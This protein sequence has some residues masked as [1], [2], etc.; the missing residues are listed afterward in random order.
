M[1]VLIILSWILDT[2]LHYHLPFLP[3]YFLYFQPLLLVT[4]LLTY[5]ILENKNRQKLKTMAIIIIIYDFLF[6][7]IYFLSFIIFFILY[8]IISYLKKRWNNSF[9]SFLILLILSINSFIIFKYLLL[10]VLNVINYSF[11]F[12]INEVIKSLILNI[13]YGIILYYFIG[14][15][16]RKM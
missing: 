15:K 5:L 2:F 12:L 1:I 14:I 3:S 7:K 13:L 9:F 10:T 6:S 4:T 11:S 8:K 16:K